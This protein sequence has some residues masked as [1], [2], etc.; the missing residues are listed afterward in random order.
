MQL[1]QHPVKCCV[2]SALREDQLRPKKLRQSVLHQAGFYFIDVLQS[3]LGSL[4]TGRRIRP[5]ALGLLGAGTLV[6]SALPCCTCAGDMVWAVPTGRKCKPESRHE[7]LLSPEP[8]QSQDLAGVDGK[9]KW[10]CA[11]L[12]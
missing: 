5:T 7:A 9:R 2:H 12:S 4:W 1:I 3:V 8:S 11:S 6:C 10:L